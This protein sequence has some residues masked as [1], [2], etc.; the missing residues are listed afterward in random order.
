ME[1]LSSIVPTQSL[2]LFLVCGAGVLV[3]V[4]MIIIPS[5]QSTVGLD[6]DIAALKE[7]IEE[8]RILTPVFKSLFNRTKV[9]NPTGLPTT[10]KAKLAREDIHKITGRLKTMAAQ[11]GLQ[12]EELTADVNSTIENSGHLLM[13]LTAVGEFISFR[14]FLLD[15][16]T[17]PSLAHIEEIKISSV[18]GAKEI[19]LKIWLAQE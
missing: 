12:L 9:P 11:H 14:K 17:I 8:Q 2:F 4:F 3:F 6:A 15:L 19:A 18:E 5:H 10:E 16:G 13:H 1:K 7:R